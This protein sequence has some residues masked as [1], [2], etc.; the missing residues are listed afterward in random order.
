MFLKLY[1]KLGDYFHDKAD[2][3]EYGP[4]DDET[5]KPDYP[6]EHVGKLR[7]SASGVLS[8]SRSNDVHAD[9]TYNIRVYSANGGRIIECHTVSS[10]SNGY[11]ETPARLYVINDDD[12]LIE[13]LGRILMVDKL[14][15]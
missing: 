10:K 3:I 6:M 15:N 7:G 11:T 14:S 5:M 8:T 9:P 4:A 13:E 12:D 1:R 2:D